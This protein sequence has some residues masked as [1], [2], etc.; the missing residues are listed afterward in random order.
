MLPAGQGPRRMFG[1]ERGM[2]DAR[3]VNR[4]AKRLA[5]AIFVVSLCFCAICGKVLLDARHAAW[6]RAGEV[7]A[8]VVATVTSETARNIESYDL[9]LRAV[10]EGLTYPEIVNVSPELRQRLLFDRSATAKHLHAITFLDENGIVRLDSRTP[11][12]QPINRS[13][14]DFF[15]YHKANKA[16]GIHVSK[17]FV[18]VRASNHVIALSRRLSNPDGSF[19]G[20]VVGTIRLS[21]FEDLF[22]AA[23]TGPNSNVSLFRTDGTL[24]MRWPNQSTM[25]GRDMKHAGIFKALATARSGRFESVAVVDGIHRLYAYSQIADLPLAVSVG[26]ST[27]DIYA[28]WRRYTAVIGLMIVVLCGVSVTFAFY[29]ARE[30]RR[31]NEAETNLEMLAA[32]DPLTG[33]SN[34]R[35]FNAGMEREWRRAVREGC[36]L[37]LLMIDADHFKSY[38]DRNGHLGGDKLLQAL[39]AAMLQNVRRGTDVAARYGGDEF[40]ILL[41]GASAAGASQVAEDVRARFAAICSERSLAD[42]GLSM[43]VATLQPGRGQSLGS[44]VA[45]ADNALYRAKAM[46]RGRT[47]IAPEEFG[48]PVVIASAA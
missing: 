12:P 6:D 7:A 39:S 16:S 15:Q 18:T 30:M 13:G 32:T 5:A 19:A 25:I 4:P 27:Q 41:P 42:S 8:G 3:P 17:P 11:S 10:I 28:P 24:L 46:G 31:R 21:Y 47:E 38:N 33:L 36:G 35:N 20:V 45:S 43:G 14:R 2:R 37:A 44:L 29:L 40:A 9:S 48:R 1:V 26:Q 22:K 34:R 23:V